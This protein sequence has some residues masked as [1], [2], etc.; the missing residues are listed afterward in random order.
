LIEPTILFFLSF[1]ILSDRLLIHANGGNKISS[2]PE[3]LP[4]VK[5]FLF[6]RYTRAM[7]MALFPLRNPTTCATEYLGG[8]E[9]N[10]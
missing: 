7:W 1:Y 6:P 8:I 2:G 10:M 3:M 5:F 9:I 4:E